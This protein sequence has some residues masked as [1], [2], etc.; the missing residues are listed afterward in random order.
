MASLSLA[1]SRRPDRNHVS[2][3]IL[4]QVEPMDT[5]ATQVTGWLFVAAAAMT[6][7]GITFLPVPIGSFFERDDFSRVLKRLRVWIWLYRVYLFGHL[8]ALMAQ[9]A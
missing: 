9:G 2:R 5:F 8:V 1:A 4:R 7:V 6:W 3:S